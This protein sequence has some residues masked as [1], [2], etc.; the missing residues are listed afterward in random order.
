MT[1]ETRRV[2]REFMQI[3]ESLQHFPEPALIVTADHVQV[4]LWL[5]FEDSMDEVE[6][7]EMP[8]ESKSDDEGA[9][10]GNEPLD[11][12]RLHHFVRAIAERINQLIRDEEAATTVHLIV[13]QDMMALLKKELAPEVASKLAKELPVDVM[14]EDE[15]KILERIVE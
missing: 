12:E 5:T 4:R 10:I 14:N 3:P 15:V 7:L 8:T 9:I 13:P 2:K 6:T 1:R 11:D